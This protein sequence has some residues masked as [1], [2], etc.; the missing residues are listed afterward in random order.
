MQENEFYARQ[1]NLKEVG[2][3]GQR[4]IQRTKVLI[5]GAG[6]LGHPAGQYLTASGVGH[7]CLLDFDTVEA[8]NLNRQVLFNAKDV[9]SSKAKVLEERFTSQNP[10]IK[11]E[12]VVE[13]L[14]AENAEQIISQFDM[15]LDCCDN[16]S[17][18]FL[19]HDTCWL[20]KKDLVQASLYQYEG[21]IQ[22]FPYSKISDRGYLRCLW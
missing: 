11:I 15:V 12:S 17:T 20:L 22:T 10:F 18:K 16:Y 4:K 19:I 6:G 5:V 7:L 14:T 21:Q 8:S 13:K 2:E 1:I 3:R 9:G